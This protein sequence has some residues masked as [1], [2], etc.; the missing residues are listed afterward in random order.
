ML[1]EVRRAPLDDAGRRALSEI[2]ERSLARARRRPLPRPPPGARRGRRCRSRARR[3]ASRSCASRRRSSSAGSKASSTASR[4]RCSP[5]RRMAQRQFE[6]MRR[7]RA[8]E[9]RREPGERTARARTSEHR[10]PMTAAEPLPNVR[11][12]TR[13]LARASRAAQQPDWPDAGALDAALDELRAVPP[14]VFAGEA[15]TLHRRARRGRRGRR[16]SCCTPATA[17]SR[18]P[19]FS[20]DNIRDKLKVILQMSVVLTYSTRRA[21]GEDR[22]HRRASSP[23]PARRPPR[24]RDGVEL[25]SF[26]GDMVNDFAFDAAARRPD[27]QRMVRGYHQAAS[28]LNLLRAFTKGGFADLPRRAR[29]GTSSSSTP[30][31]RAAATTRSPTRS[32]ARCGSWPRAASTSTPRRSST[33]STSTRRTKR[34]SSA[35]RRR[36]PGATASPA[37]GTTAR[38]TCSGSASAPASS[39][40]RTSSSSPASQNPIGVK[41]G[42]DGH[43]RRG[44]SRCASGSTPA[45][46]PGRLM[47]VSRM[48]ADHVAE[49]APAARCA[50]CS[51]PAT[52]SCGR[53]TRCTATR[54]RTRAAT[55]PAHFDDVMREL[56]A[57]LRRVRRRRR[58]AGRR[59]RRAHRRQRHRVPR[60]RPT[61]SCGDDLEQRYETSCDPRLN[62]RQ[63]LDLAFQARR[64]RSAADGTARTASERSRS[65]A[66]TDA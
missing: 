13:Q 44:A 4:P 54:S 63:S 55:R 20:A 10:R 64:A 29:S 50:R 15:R 3:R 9:Q 35:T 66:S 17:R 51:A 59:A 25:P 27:P 1:D 34:C 47:L 58:V 18:S 39:T 57:V 12:G 24:Q 33:R 48:G 7:R 28:T 32:T 45:A 5:S 49:R 22:P 14:L 16:R 11:L 61:R 19:T 46:S 2:H 42:P 65:D 26:R 62:A 53:A 31:P 6:E 23:S 60:R 52:R 56:A 36:S 8:L 30:A 38:R 43:A 40:A 21:D 41:L 37:T